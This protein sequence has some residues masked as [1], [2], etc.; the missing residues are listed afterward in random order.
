MREIEVIL[1]E[2][3]KGTN[4]MNDLLIAHQR[5]IFRLG[6]KDSLMVQNYMTEETSGAGESRVPG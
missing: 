3:N 5:R 1:G 4:E 6:S 2:T